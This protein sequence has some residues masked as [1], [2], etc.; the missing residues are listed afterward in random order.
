MNNKK[1]GKLILAAVIIVIIGLGAKYALTTKPASKTENPESKVLAGTTAT[2]QIFDKAD[3]EAALASDKLIVLYFYANWCP[4]C[5]AELPETYA[6]F[7][8]LETD[9]VI[10]FRV[11]YNDNDT[12]KDEEAL[13]KEFQ[14]PYQHTKVFVLNGKQ[15][16]KSP[17]S[18]DKNRY[19]SE[20]TNNLK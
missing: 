9:K 17:E 3:Y 4:I 16:L 20:I 1:G 15:I 8:E 12:D 5:K 19:L 13:A 18:W 10:G 7:N 6:A 2:F 14:V 11:N